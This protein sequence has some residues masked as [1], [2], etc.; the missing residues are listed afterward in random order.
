MAQLDIKIC[1]ISN[2]ED[3]RVALAAGADYVGFVLYPPSP[4]GVSVEEMKRIL[5]ELDVPARAVGVF[6][7]QSRRAVLDVVR[8][9]GLAVAQIH[10][11]EPATEFANMP[12]TTWRAVK[13]ADGA[14]VPDPGRWA[15]DRYVIDAD[16]PGMYGGTGVAADWERAAELAAGHAVMLAGGLT[17]ANVAQAVKEVRPRGVD[18]A[19]GVEREPGRKDPA[20][21]RAFIAAAREGMNGT[22]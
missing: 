18:V 20:A 4:R 11:D 2:V 6:V 15:A 9:C 5:G 17:P 10:G 13:V 21:V 1:G 3:A 8:D 19:S 7:N 14:I 22:G 16:V 12:V